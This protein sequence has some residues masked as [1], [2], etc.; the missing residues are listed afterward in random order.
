MLMRGDTLLLCEPCR[1]CLDER[2][3]GVPSAPLGHDEIQEKRE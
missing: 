1:K 3:E 2:E